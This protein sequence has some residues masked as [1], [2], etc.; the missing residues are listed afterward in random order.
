VR[1]LILT[2]ARKGSIAVNKTLALRLTAVVSL[3]STL[4]MLAGVPIAAGLHGLGGPGPI[5]FGNSEVLARLAQATSRTIW[6][7]A[8][9]LLGPALALVAGTGVFLLIE[10]DRPL[11]WIGTL[12]WYAGMLFV[13]TQDAL[14]LALVTKLPAAYM[15]AEPLIRPAIEAFGASLAYAIRVL[16]GVGQLSGLGFMIQCVALL[17][18]PR[19]P[20]WIPILGLV[21]NGL[22][23]FSTSASLVLP[24]PG[25]LAL[26]VPIGL[27]TL[28]F[29][30]NPALAL[31]M[32]RWKDAPSA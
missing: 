20:R 10:R 28:I 11:A 30:C 32:W 13:V 18:L 1:R 16:A 25:I 26:G 5:D 19:V 15:A 27:L 31:V 24:S 4:V 6:V 21:A 22:A 12:L 14:Q 29:V 9:A 23:I 2:R 3:I 8:L 7:D 17:R